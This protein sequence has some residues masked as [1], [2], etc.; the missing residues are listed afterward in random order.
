[1]LENVSPLPSQMLSNARHNVTGC[2]PDV[3]GIKVIKSCR[4]KVV[5]DTQ[6]EIERHRIFHAEHVADPK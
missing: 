1:M 2:F 5:K 6:T 3:T 4:S